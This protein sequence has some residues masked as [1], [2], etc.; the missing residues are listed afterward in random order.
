MAT[1][2][3]L[4]W[5]KDDF[6]LKNNLALAKATHKHDH[7]VAFYL[8]KIK[9]LEKQ[10]AQKW[11][12]SKSL[13]NFKNKLDKLNIKLEIIKTDTYKSFFDKL[14]TKK[15]FS[16]YWNKTYE[17]NYIKFDKYLSKNFKENK[18]EFEILKGNILNEIDEIKKM[19]GSPFKVFRPYWRNAEKFC[20]EKIPA[21]ERKISTCNKK[22]SFFKNTVDENEI[23]PEKNWFKKFEKYWDPS[24]ENA[25]KE[26]KNFLNNRIK[27]YSESRNFPNKIGTSRLSP[28]IKHGQIHVDTIW[29][30]CIKIKNKGAS[31]FL[32]EIGW[33]EF[34]HTLINNFSHMLSGNY[35]KSSTI[36]LGRKIQNIYLL[37]KK[38]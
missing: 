37:G 16:I 30:E 9:Q 21:K 18:I 29:Q 25:L 24:E 12:I 36:F 8:Y 26:L 34:N 5:I 28:Y 33:R 11:W 4:F 14:F 23:N 13:K 32:S 7:V 20:L 38:D 10:Q 3:G 35:S 17:P 1:N 27:D 19:D 15:N 2:I 31:T 6:R 22:V